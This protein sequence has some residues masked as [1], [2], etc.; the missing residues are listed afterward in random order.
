MITPHPVEGIVW[1][2]TELAQ[3]IPSRALPDPDAIDEV[4]RSGWA[5]KCRDY[6]AE[7]DSHFQ[8]PAPL[9]DLATRVLARCNGEDEPPGDVDLEAATVGIGRCPVFAAVPWWV[10]ARGLEFALEAFARSYEFGHH[11]DANGYSSTVGDWLVEREVSS[12]RPEYADGAWRLLREQAT[13]ASDEKWSSARA[14][15]QRLFEKSAA[16]VQAGIAFMFDDVALAD[17][18]IENAL[19]TF[20]PWANKQRSVYAPHLA[21]LVGVASSDAARRILIGRNTALGVSDLY[22]ALAKHGHAAVP[23]IATA[24]KAVNSP[25]QSKIAKVLLAVRTDEAAELLTSWA[26]EKKAIAPL[27]KKHLSLPRR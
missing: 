25:L 10:E 26:A 19:P 18:A 14:V 8:Y 12:S 16:P 23:T 15:A 11:A 22:T 17:Q 9:Q 2:K 27:L 3:V 24:Y 1:S 21:R 20:E 4:A 5:E 6:R 7:K 13:R